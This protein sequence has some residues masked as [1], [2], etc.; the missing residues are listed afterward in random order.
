MTGAPTEARNLKAF[1]TSAGESLRDFAALDRHSFETP[2]S[3]RAFGVTLAAAEAGLFTLAEFQR[4]LIGR[5]GVHEQ[6]GQKI[7]SDE[8]YYECWIGALVDLLCA[9]GLIASEALATAEEGIRA[10]VREM[11]SHDHD[12]HHLRPVRIDAAR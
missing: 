10:A 9:K 12:H 2:W 11:H 1:V 3:A 4:A 6:A 5:I 8:I 7:D